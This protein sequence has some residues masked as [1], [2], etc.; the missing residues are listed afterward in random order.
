MKKTHF[1]LIELLV[2]VAIIGILASLLLPSLGKARESARR[3]I[4]LNNSKSHGIALELYGD[5][6]DRNVP[7][8]GTMGTP[9]G[10]SGNIWF[11]KAGTST[12]TYLASIRYLNQYLGAPSDDSETPFSQCISEKAELNRYGTYG[13]SYFR[14]NALRWAKNNTEYPEISLN[15]IL[16]PS[17]FV[18]M[19]E[20]GG[21]WVIA[22]A[23]RVDK[24]EFYN[25][26]EFGDTR[27]NLLYG[28]G[29]VQ[30]TKIMPG[31]DTTSSYT[32]LL[33][34]N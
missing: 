8:T 28:D 27:W 25:H 24:P 23:G 22:Q 26:S 3:T 10:T 14:N 9:A 1:T 16:T 31:A 21:L 17:K 15:D 32:T 18:S 19:G 20:H 12:A 5:D 6:N 11:G 30:Y 33:D 13:N 29:H 34:G 4:C 7:P 2:V